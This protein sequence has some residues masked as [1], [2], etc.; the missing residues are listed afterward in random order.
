MTQLLFHLAIKELKRQPRFAFLFIFNIALGLVGLLTLHTLKTAF[1][2]SVNDQAKPLLG[3]DLVVSA[4]RP[5][6]AE[7]QAI[8][9]R[10]LGSAKKA[11]SVETLSMVAHGKKTRLIQLRGVD[12]AFPFY[13]ELQLRKMGRVSRIGEALNKAGG[14]WLHPELQV[15]LGVGVGDKIRLGD[16]EFEI[17]DIVEKDIPA[18]ASFFTLAPRIYLP[19][20]KLDSTKLL[21]EGSTATYSQFYRLPEDVDIEK[22]AKELESALKDLTL[23]VLTYK[24]ASQEIGRVGKSLNDYLGL[25]AL[26]ALFLSTLSCGYLLRS[27]LSTRLDQCAVLRSLGLSSDNVRNLYLIQVSLLAVGACIPAI[28]L[29]AVLAPFGGVLLDQFFPVHLDPKI[30]SAG[31]TLALLLGIGLSWLVAFPFLSALKQISPGRLF[32]EAASPA[33]N[34]RGKGLFLFIPLVA[35]LWGLSVWQARSIFLGSVFVGTLLFCSGALL[36]FVRIGFVLLD[37]I[38]AKSSFTLRMA[39]LRLSRMRLSSMLGFVTIALACLLVSLVAQIQRGLVGQIQRPEGFVLP[40]LFLFD[41]QEEQVAELKSMLADKKIVLQGLSPLV[42][43][44]IE[45][46]NGKAYESLFDSHGTFSRDEE[47]EKRFRNR[48]VNLSFRSALSGSEKIVEGAPFPVARSNREYAYLSVETEFGKRAHLKR[49][50]KV[51][52]DVQG[53]HLQAEVFNLRKVRWVSFQPNFFIEVEPGFLDDAPK[54]FVAT[55]GDLSETGKEDVQAEMV[56]KFPNVSMVDVG[57]AVER[58]TSVLDQ[59]AWA[60]RV[61]AFLTGLAGVAVLI[62]IAVDQARNRRREVVLLNLLG[63]SPRQL[64]QTVFWENLTL[65]MS[66]SFCGIALSLFVSSFLAHYFFDERWEFATLSALLIPL[67]V[68]SLTSTIGLLFTHHALAQKPTL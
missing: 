25:V 40:S 23:R 44:R 8:L 33:W 2:T 13:G 7:E 5:L 56:R 30:S 15:Q 38:F 63:M 45:Q 11:L 42:R 67:I 32:Q 28:A 55:L 51:V 34:V 37:G 9:E 46:V 60:L 66:A 49:G 43:A 39:W 59:M 6:L 36:V 20:S 10:E 65:G 52:F 19:L 12:T 53:V 21:R 31:V 61:M 22:K 57:K 24:N 4:R 35:A 48:G 41:I 64:F 14:V 26:V 58:I 50:D 3:G 54:T 1:E 18:S 47:Q 68:S 29:S 16:A 62:S 27:F 17:K